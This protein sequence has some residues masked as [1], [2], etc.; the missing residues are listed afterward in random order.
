MYTVSVCALLTYSLSYLFPF[1]FYVYIFYSDQSFLSLFSSHSL[2]AHPTYMV[3]EVLSLNSQ[4]PTS[5]P[6]SNTYAQPTQSS[7]PPLFYSEKCR[8]PMDI[9]K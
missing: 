3:W 6:S 1:Y 7:I 8:P 2:P 5:G 4:E 9:N